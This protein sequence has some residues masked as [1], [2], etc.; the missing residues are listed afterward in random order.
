MAGKRTIGGNPAAAETAEATTAAPKKPV[1]L[2][3]FSELWGTPKTEEAPAISNEQLESAKVGTGE[4]SALREER[5]AMPADA[6][7]EESKSRRLVSAAADLGR[8]GFVNPRKKVSYRDQAII[9]HADLTNISADL[10]NKIEEL[11]R[12][13]PIT[14]N[15]K[16][17][18][19]YDRLHSIL[20]LADHHI[21]Q[22]SIEHMRGHYGVDYLDAHPNMENKAVDGVGLSEIRKAAQAG[23]DA[24]GLISVAPVIPK[25][26]INFTRRAAKLLKQ[27]SAHL[28]TISV[29]GQAAARQNKS[30][31]APEPFDVDGAIQKKIDDVSN[32]YANTIDVG[33]KLQNPDRQQP[34]GMAI[35]T[36]A[37]EESKRINTPDFL[38]AVGEP[39]LGASRAADIKSMFD[40]RGK[41]GQALAA[42][43]KVHA[44]IQRTLAWNAFHR[45][46]GAKLGANE[47]AQNANMDFI[48]PALQRNAEVRN[49]NAY[50]AARVGTLRQQ[51]PVTPVFADMP[52]AEKVARDLAG[53]SVSIDKTTE[54][55]RLLL[56]NLPTDSLIPRAKE[57][58]DRANAA[59]DTAR[60]EALKGHI[61][62]IIHHTTLRDLNADPKRGAV[63]K[64]GSSAAAL[65]LPTEQETIG[66]VGKRS[67]LYGNVGGPNPG[68]SADSLMTT[69]DY[70][71]RTLSDSPVPIQTIER[72]SGSL[73]AHPG[74]AM[75]ELTKSSD[76]S[77]NNER[78]AANKTELESE[79]IKP[80]RKKNLLKENKALEIT[81]E[82]AKDSQDKIPAL[83]S[84]LV[85]YHAGAI[86]RSTEALGLA[87][88]NSGNIKGREGDA[89]VNTGI[90]AAV[91]PEE[92]LPSREELPYPELPYPELPDRKS[93]FRRFMVTSGI[94]R[95]PNEPNVVQ[96][97][98]KKGNPLDYKK[99]RKRGAVFADAALNQYAY[100]PT[101]KVPEDEAGFYKQEKEVRNQPV[102]GTATRESFARVQQSL[103]ESLKAEDQARL[104]AANAEDEAARE[105]GRSLG[106]PEELLPMVTSGSNVRGIL[107]L[108]NKGSAPLVSA[109][110]ESAL[111]PGIGRVAIPPRKK[112]QKK[113]KKGKLTAADLLPGLLDSNDKPEVSS[114]DVRKLIR[115]GARGDSAANGMEEVDSTAAPEKLGRQFKGYTVEG[116]TENEIKKLGEV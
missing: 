49:G 116:A 74:D 9:G 75:T 18:S 92:A 5:E 38:S 12:Q 106:I 67:N 84:A 33:H 96:L 17:S 14:E 4:T 24:K 15:G 54:Q 41:A 100:G 107:P 65:K 110:G 16:A 64:S 73:A 47:A 23:T 32:E 86:D 105:K 71:D 76:I 62:S 99:A 98:D 113:A 10:G 115:K 70:A 53:R 30:L 72:A 20:D 69:S 44:T 103:G 114:L 48:K 57:A 42:A 112:V 1:T 27:A 58:I 51:F 111:V 59:G 45:I 87:L 90:Q 25:G 63:I 22:A 52:V 77:D 83:K 21:A 35:S 2:P 46:F 39:E 19:M 80:N 97:R 43:K 89:P 55:S 26:S 40:R 109:S 56:K 81:N 79:E 101:F 78:I 82:N 11:R 60:A 13:V 29:Q 66:E 8:K 37:R 94:N 3:D 6:F 68:V 102:R 7:A 34:E 28:T 50:E 108:G 61:D 104:A 31:T 88:F 95:N 91:K 36:A 93:L 85:A